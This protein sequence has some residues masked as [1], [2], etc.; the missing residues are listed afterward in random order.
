MKTLKNSYKIDNIDNIYYELVRRLMSKGYTLED[1]YDIMMMLG[2]STGSWL[3]LELVWTLSI[4][5]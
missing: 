3:K 2:I 4:D 1:R 5:E